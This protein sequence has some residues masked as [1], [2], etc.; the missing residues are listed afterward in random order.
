MRCRGA[1]G[2]WAESWAPEGV[3]YLGQVQE[4]MLGGA[5]DGG[6]PA[7]FTLGFLQRAAVISQDGFHSEFIL[8]IVRNRLFPVPKTILKILTD[9]KSIRR[10]I[11]HC[12]LK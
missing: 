4:E 6:L 7:H 9:L 11:F 8:F 3:R 5:D 12:L 10:K 2:R 1:G